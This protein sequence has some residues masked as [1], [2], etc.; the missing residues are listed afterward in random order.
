MQVWESAQR[1]YPFFR[2]A[3][4][5]ES[6]GGAVDVTP[7]ALA[8]ISAIDQ[9]PGLF[10]STGFSGGGFGAA[11]G[12]GKLVSELLTGC[13]PDVDPTP[14]SHRRFL[15]PTSRHVAGPTFS[16]QASRNAAG[17]Q[18]SPARDCSR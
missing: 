4:V 5:A 12:A 8:V 17:S 9:V 2:R 11:P 15:E 14:Y 7:D 13:T 18:E 3:A 16:D 6:W 10:V 1:L